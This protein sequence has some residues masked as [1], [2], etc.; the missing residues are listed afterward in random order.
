VGIACVVAA[1]GLWRCSYW[2]FMSAGVIVLLFLAMHVLRA[3]HT[4]N[5]WSLV[6]ILTIVAPVMWCLRRRVRVFEDRT[7]EP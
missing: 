1:L 7:V 2:G 6:V 4:N 5:W 3:L